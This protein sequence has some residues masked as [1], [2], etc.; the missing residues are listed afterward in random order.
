MT[1]QLE[2]AAPPLRIG[3]LVNSAIVPKYDAEFIRWAHTRDDIEV[4]HLILH[5]PEDNPVSTPQKSKLGRMLAVLAERGLKGTLAGLLWQYI[6]WSEKRLLARHDELLRGHFDTIDVSAEVPEQLRITPIVSPSGFVFRFGP[7]DIEAV[8]KLDLDLM[9]RCGDGILKG[10]L[11]TSSR[12]GVLSFHHAD[13]RVNRGGPPAFW[14]TYYRQSQTS[15]TIQKLSSVLDGGEVYSRGHFPTQFPY[16]ANESQLFAKANPFMRHVVTEIAATRQLPQ[17][18]PSV[19]YSARLFRRPNILQMTRYLAQRFVHR[20]RQQ[21]TYRAG[22]KDLWHV[23]YCNS[24]WS[25]AELWRGPKIPNPPGTF[26]ADPFVITRD[27]KTYCFVEEL[28]LKIDKA[29]I[30]VYELGKD[31]ATPLG[32]VLEE[33]FHLSFPYLFEYNNELFMCPETSAAGDIR[34]YQ[35]DEFPMK[36][37]LREIL[38]PEFYAAD[39]MLFEHDGRWWM[40][41]NTDEARID[42]FCSELN[43][44]WSDSPL[45]TDWTPHKQNPVMIDSARARNGGLLQQNGELFRVGQEQGFVTYGKRSRIHRITELTPEHYAEEEVARVMP[46]FDD[47][48]HGGHHLHSNGKVTVFDYRA[49]VRS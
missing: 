10:D 31:A 7:E 12:F 37:S 36:W 24:D 22:Y 27:E 33:P 45:S 25:N 13:N 11:L 43:I 44:F 2:P 20:L 38:M 30:S 35:C 1:T 23:G 47:G 5:A 9:I 3:L 18:L 46:E 34:V 42:E 21:I 19:P 4:T 16:L 15:F 6:E 14:E 17:A 8:R 41:T 39:T 32:A 48:A 26:L 29:L 28:D 49:L 40:F